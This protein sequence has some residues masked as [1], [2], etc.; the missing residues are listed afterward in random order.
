MLKLQDVLKDVDFNDKDRENMKKIAL[1]IEEHK[2]EIV[3]EVANMLYKDPEMAKALQKGNFTVPL[4]KDVLRNKLDLMFP[5]EFDEEYERKVLQYVKG[6]IST[7]G[8]IQGFSI[9][10]V[11][12]I[13]TLFLLLKV[14]EKLSSLNLDNFADLSKTIMKLVS[15]FLGIAID[16]YAEQL[17]GYFLKFTGMSNELF[18]REIG[19]E[20][21]KESEKKV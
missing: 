14:D 5:S 9:L 13:D 18:Q 4:V 3:D 6:D 17:L 19:L 16:L 7:T 20:V 10:T 11:A 8:A 21:K 1:I 2:D 12:I 15:V